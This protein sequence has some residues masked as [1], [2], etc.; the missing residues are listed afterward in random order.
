M[1]V[2]TDAVPPVPEHTPP[3]Q[4]DANNPSGT[5]KF[6]HVWTRWFVSLR[7]KVNVINEQLTSLS[8]LVGSGLVVMDGDNAIERSIEGTPGR[9]NVQNGDGIGGNPTID[10]I[11]SGIT[12]GTQAGGMNT[13]A[14]TFDE[15]G[16]AT[17]VSAV[18][19]TDSSSATA[20][21][22]AALPATPAGYILVSIDL[23][24][25]PIP[26]KIPYFEP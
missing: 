6:N 20:G 1:S 26:V 4:E 24:S 15:F 3:V 18:S 7:A 10:L 13:P 17:G 12:P 16:M 14:I 25:G 21:S 19:Y 9:I 23:G 22:A 8:T 5:R 11:A 2:E